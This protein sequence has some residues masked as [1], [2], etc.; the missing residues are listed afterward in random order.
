MFLFPNLVRLFKIDLCHESRFGLV[1][2]LA[3]EYLDMDSISDYSLRDYFLPTLGPSFI[4]MYS[5][6][7]NLRV[8]TMDQ[9]EENASDYE[10]ED[11]DDDL[12]ENKDRTPVQ[13]RTTRVRSYPTISGSKPGGGEYVAR[14]LISINAAK[15]DSAKNKNDELTQS[16]KQSVNN[17]IRQCSKSFTLFGMISECVL[18]DSRYQ[19]DLSFQI[20]MGYY[21]FS[22]VF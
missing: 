1:S 8:R 11:D 19:G 20:C 17:L 22:I 21:L 14:L 9:A 5:D 4:D 16:K 3:S 18:Q 6:P 7:A 15:A 13:K 12:D 10:D 2:I